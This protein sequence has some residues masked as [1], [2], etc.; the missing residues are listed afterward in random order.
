M[1]EKEM[2]QIAAWIDLVFTKKAE[3]ATIKR[4]VLALCK[5]F[6]TP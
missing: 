5:K 4:D 3:V 2:K 1:K 6:P